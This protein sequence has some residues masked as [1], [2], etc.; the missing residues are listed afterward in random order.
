MK[1]STYLVIMSE[2]TN[3]PVRKLEKLR[4]PRPPSRC[5]RHDL[6][7][8]SYFQTDK[9]PHPLTL[10]KYYFIS[11]A[12]YDTNPTVTFFTKFLDSSNKTFPIFE[13]YRTFYILYH[14]TSS[15][16]KHLLME[17]SLFIC[18]FPSLILHFYFRSLITKTG[19]AHQSFVH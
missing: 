12:F 3:I 16:N 13:P 14:I 5:K 19:E 8:C 6:S 1:S 7:F 4:K 18:A 2:C 17:E 9:F 11:F 10:K 15:F